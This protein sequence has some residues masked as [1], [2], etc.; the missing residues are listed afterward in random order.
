MARW[1]QA[2]WLRHTGARR[3]G[4]TVQRQ[5][6]RRLIA[7]SLE[8]RMLLTT[9]SSVVPQANV[10]DAPTST[11]ISATFDQTLNPATVTDQSFTAHA[12]QSGKLLGGTFNVAGNVVTLDPTSD[13]RPGEAVLV[14]ATD[15][16]QSNVGILATPH[17]WQFQTAVDHG[18]AMFADSGQDVGGGSGI[19]V[20][21]GDLDGDDDLDAF[22][23]NAPEG[24]RVWINHDGVFSDSLQ[25]L[26][27]HNSVS[28]ALGDLDGDGDLD[29]FV[30]NANEGNRVWINAGGTFSDSGQ[31]LGVFDSFGVSLGDLDGD[32]DLDAFVANRLQGN[33]IWIND[34]GVFTDSGQSLG[35]HSSYG[36]ALGDL[37]NDGDL[38][39]FVANT[40]ESNRI[41]INTAGTFSDSGQTLGDH[42]SLS[43][44]LGDLDGDGDLDAFVANYYQGNRVW[45][46]DAGVFTDTEQE[47][48]NHSSY[49]V[50]LGDLDGDSD[51]DALVVN[52]YQSNRVWLNEAGTFVS[53]GQSLGDHDSSSVALGDID[54]DG[55]LDAFVA[56]FNQ[57]NRIWI[58]QNPTLSISPEELV[59]GEGDAGP[60]QFTFVVERA[61]DT[62][63]T[64]MVD[65]EFAPSGANAADASDFVGSAFTSGTLTFADGVASMPLT[66]EVTGDSTV[67]PD[68]SFTVSLSNPVGRNAVLGEALAAGLVRNDDNV[69]L[70]DLPT[71]FPTLLVNNGPAHVAVGPFL[72]SGRDIESDGQPSADATGDD[73]TGIPDDE[74]GV[75]FDSL[76]FPGY[77]T[78]RIVVTASATSHLDAWLDFN[79][80]RV[81]DGANEQIFTSKPLTAGQNLLQFAVPADARQG[82]TFA[83][84]RVSSTGGLAPTGGAIDG[85]VEDY[86]LSI[87]APFGSGVFGNTGQSLG[88]HNTNAFVVGDLDGDG[89][90]DAFAANGNQ[91]A[92]RIWLSNGVQLSDSGQLLGDGST[93]D[94]A[95]GDVDGDGDLDAVTANVGE[96]RVWLNNNGLFSDSGQLLGNSTSYGIKLGDLDL[97]G[98][99][100]AFF[101]NSGQ[102]NQVW[103]NE[104]GAFTNSNQNLGDA[105]S[106]DVELGDVD[107]DGDIDAFVANRGQANRV[108][109]NSNGQF[110]ASTQL[111]GSHNSVSVA[112]A[113]LDNDG[114]LDAFVSNDAQGNRVWV[115]LAGLFVDTGQSLGDHNS[116]DVALGDV[117]GD[118]DLDAIVVNEGP[119]SRIWLNDSAAFTAVD[120]GLAGSAVSLGDL[121]RDGDLDALLAAY[122]NG[123]QVLTDLAS[124]SLISIRPL[125]TASAEGNSSTTPFAFEVTRTGDTSVPGGVSFQVGGT[126]T[127][128]AD[129]TDFGGTFPAD[130]LTFA[131]GETTQTIMIDVTGD[132]EV[133]ADEEF[134]VILSAPQP[135]GA[136]LVTASASAT[137]LNDD[138]PSVSVAL[139]AVLDN[140]L[141]ETVDG[142][143]SNGAGQWFFAGR[144]GVTASTRIHRGLIQFDVAGT[145]PAGSTI[146]NVTLT[147]N[148][149]RTSSDSNDVRLHRVTSPWG[150]GTSDAFGVEGQGTAATPNDATWLHNFF[151]SSTWTTPGGDFVQ[152]AS[153]TTIVGDL[154]AYDWTGPGLVADVQSWLDDGSE[155]GW[156]VRGEETLVQRAQRFVSHESPIVA[157]R[158]MLVV[159]Y[160]PPPSILSISALDAEK[161]E[162]DSEE[163]AFTFTVTRSGD[164]SG[165]TTIDYSVTGVG[166]NPVDAEDFGGALPNGTVTFE[167]QD[168]AQ[169]ISIE[170]SGDLIFEPDEQFQVTLSNPS[171]PSSQIDVASAIGTVLNDD[172]PLPV[173]TL[174]SG[175][176]QIAEAAGTTTLT[177]TLSATAVLP[178]TITLDLSGT[179][180][181]VDDYAVSATQII[182]PAGANSGQITV[183]AVQDDVAEP[184]EVLTATIV[185][186]ENAIIDGVQAQTITIVDDDDPPPGPPTVTTVTPTAGSH[187]ASTSSDIEAVFDQP[188]NPVTVNFNSFGVHSMTRGQITGAVAALSTTDNAITMNPNLDFFPGEQVAATAS[189]SILGASGQPAVPFVWQ[190]RAGVTSGTAVFNDS[191]QQLGSAN[192]YR[193]ELG[194]LDSDGDLDAF[195]ANSSEGNT[196]WFN[197]QGTF[198]LG[199]TLTAHLTLDVALGDLD[200]DGDL[201]AFVTNLSQ[202]N[203]VLLNDGGTFTDSGQALGG[204]NSFGIS[205]GDVDGDGDLDAFVANLDSP[206]RV[207][208]NSSGVFTDS[209]QLLGDHASYNASLGDLD[210]DGDLDAFVANSDQANRI[211]W[212]ENSVFSD[213]GQSLGTGSSRD[214]A[215][216]D[217]DGD[218]DAD[219]LVANYGEPNRLW[220][221]E[222]GNFSD[223]GQMLGSF[224]ST[225]LSL[226]DLDGDGDLDAFVANSLQSDG[227][228]LNDGGTLTNSGQNLG[229]HTSFGVALG[230]LD[231][232]G[233]LDGFVT[234]NNEANRIWLNQNPTLSISP[235]MVSLAEGDT[236]TT[237]FTFTITREFDSRGTAEVDFAFEASGSDPAEL[238]DFAGGVLPSDSLVFADGVESLEVTIQVLGDTFVEGDE[239]FALQLSNPVNAQLDAPA[240]RR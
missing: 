202:A 140:T 178:A 51:L 161:A 193:V 115:N 207:W 100:D 209:G 101:A 47:L 134:E 82:Q 45:R 76:I 125:E 14:T 68:E 163:A 183:T 96:N 40:Y 39:A 12:S 213:S 116:T 56:N 139:P 44:A 105:N 190:F 58:N 91:Q 186:A 13:L 41:W 130:V 237:T 188:I 211:W 198:T 27:D 6:I 199:Q 208:L 239:G 219:A 179:A 63:D 17:V 23:A 7:E 136:R 24:N 5:E 1:K 223:S 126:G 97:D 222:G 191:G 137:I 143:L 145:V 128:A 184:D 110:V 225:D 92:N 107:G 119:G 212:N 88:D 34:G 172:A 131:A 78:A 158:P 113:D 73:H 114:D 55:D 10:H 224:Q 86:E 93:M 221:N 196:V 160:L 233:D 46:N 4:R 2:R 197:D 187:D 236:G 124:G 228:W 37:D 152:T 84:F 30:T 240:V 104:G 94:V 231:G 138:V 144:T 32:G 118:G 162:G 36:V 170:V 174:S 64:V 25:S 48:G 194:D 28:V 18:S 232:D 29:A 26:G 189:N 11:D 35:A 229:A 166:G 218:G 53:S 90:L 15:S 200:G 66:I 150:E 117:D 122:G 38:D 16:I 3:T 87:V 148:M 83:R 171:P 168:T 201:D 49:S 112:L 195:V 59:L 192:S 176:A 108:W 159:E 149:D 52:S 132:F 43:V 127:D 103:I 135:V 120:L 154:G 177:A 111:L 169:T 157:A 238:D 85:E 42:E 31:S 181:L 151:N 50:A 19:A 22:V 77:Q 155:F 57:S 216:G 109:L 165:A 65:F 182:I 141:Y 185:A 80:D 235:A 79:G 67:E 72:G 167:A 220:L 61:F 62:R 121:D 81:L 234:N 99:L 142:G 75:A 9:V 226:G 20:A 210:G 153:A 173:V 214:V 205:L 69:D 129:E 146:T 203:R 33:R 217:F 102:P 204:N 206:N 54:N 89:D 164:I 180:T 98:D 60:T 70:G 156:L 8:Q 106:H 123:N 74:D 95:L 71:P 175:A 227:V 133:E 21:L 147:L 230:D 215:L